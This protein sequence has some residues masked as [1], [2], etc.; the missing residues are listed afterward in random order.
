MRTANDEVSRDN[1]EMYFV[2]VFAGIVDLSSGELAYCNAGHENPYA[3]DVKHSTLAR[4]SQG[5]GP[6]LCTVEHFAYGA[7]NHSLQPGELLCLVTD[8][9]VD[10]Q[11][12]AGERYGSERLQGL[13]ARLAKGDTTARDVVD[14][15]GADVRTFV[16]AADPADDVT[17][18]ALRWLGPGGT[19]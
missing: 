6:P 9:I 16:G 1:P 3:L 14:A 18:L 7:G 12:P 11:N 4:L 19:A 8:G 13:L 5:A 10:A 17:V 2:T 15:V